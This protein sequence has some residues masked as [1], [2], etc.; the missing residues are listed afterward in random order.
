M[1]V[2]VGDERARDFAGPTR[3]FDGA[4]RWNSLFVHDDDTITAV[5]TTT[6]EGVAGLWAIH[7]R[8]RPRVD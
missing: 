8:I 6:A 1:A 3:P 5:S 7:G 4:S 2:Y